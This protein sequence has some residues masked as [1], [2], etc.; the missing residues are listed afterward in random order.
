MSCNGMMPVTVQEYLS[1]ISLRS[2]MKA[3]I[4]IDNIVG[5]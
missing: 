3:D 1:K 4:K 5:T 2:K